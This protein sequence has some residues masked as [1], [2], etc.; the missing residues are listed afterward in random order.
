MQEEIKISVYFGL[1]NLKFDGA[2]NPSK[3][4][5]LEQTNLSPQYKEKIREQEAKAEVFERVIDREINGIEAD[6][7][8]NFLESRGI[9]Y[10]VHFTDL[11]NIESINEYGLLSREELKKRNLKYKYN[12]SK[13]LDKHLDYIS[14]SI[15]NINEYLFERF[16]RNGSIKKPYIIYIDATI[17]YKEFQTDR[18]YCD[19]NAA[20]SECGQGGSVNDFEKMFPELSGC[21]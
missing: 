6:K 20:T 18:I 10:L 2:L 1:L 12:D 21:A 17:L 16:K 13:R 8:K 5:L 4:C 3:L 11:E 7:I 15:T 14:L 9:E 19:R